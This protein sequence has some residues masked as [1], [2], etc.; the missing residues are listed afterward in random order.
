[1]ARPGVLQE[2]QFASFKKRRKEIRSKVKAQSPN[3]WSFSHG[4]GGE[5]L[6]STPLLRFYRRSDTSSSAVVTAPVW[7]VGFLWSCD[8]IWNC[9]TILKRAKTQDCQALISLKSVKVTPANSIGN[10]IY[11]IWLL[12][13]QNR[14]EFWEISLSPLFEA[15]PWKTLKA[16]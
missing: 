5:W 3:P 1:M 2:T 15:S 6:K 7:P 12:Q 16:F 13:P 9:K 14:K 8:F 10:G 4:G 11:G